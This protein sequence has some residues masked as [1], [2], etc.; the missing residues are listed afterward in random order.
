R[1]MSEGG[2]RRIKRPLYIDMSTIRFLTEAEI[3][4]F[5]DF[6]VLRDYMK[7]KIDEIETY[8]ARLE[9]KAKI[10]ANARH[11]TNIGTFRA[12]VI[13]YLKNHPKVHQNM[14]QLV[15][16]LNPTPHGLPLEIYVF[17]NDTN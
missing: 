4:T 5:C 8:N 2:G 17:T 11:L 7:A 3:K 10:V 6:L 13:H 15:R 14:T 12:Y 16:Q 1:S 9:D